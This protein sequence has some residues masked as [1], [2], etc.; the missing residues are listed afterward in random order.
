MEETDGSP[1]QMTEPAKERPKRSKRKLSM[2]DMDASPD[3]NFKRSGISNTSFF[4][5]Y[6]SL[7]H[8]SHYCVLRI[9]FKMTSLCNFANCKAVCYAFTA[10]CLCVINHICNIK[11][12]G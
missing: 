9:T 10:F 2:A 11:L 5:C 8:S 3:A 7:F 12:N 6:S 4:S 1:V